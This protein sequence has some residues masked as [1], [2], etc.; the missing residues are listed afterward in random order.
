M[1]K[2]SHC[3]AL[4]GLSRDRGGSAPGAGL[5]GALGGG[6]RAI[7]RDGE[8]GGT[9]LGVVVLDGGADNV[10]V[11]GSNRET[12]KGAVTAMGAGSPL[13]VRGARGCVEEDED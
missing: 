3:A 10:G 2:R 13:A 1:V 9:G 11:A 12:E 6:G 7:D 5:L 4:G 8:S